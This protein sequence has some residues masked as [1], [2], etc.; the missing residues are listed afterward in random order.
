MRSNKECS[1]LNVLCVIS[2]Y[3]LFKPFLVRFDNPPPLGQLE[4]AVLSG[5]KPLFH[6]RL[7][8]LYRIGS[9]TFAQVV[10]NDPAV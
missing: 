6:Q 2:F 1:I 4:G 9:S 3:I 8:Y 7:C 5:N 10:A